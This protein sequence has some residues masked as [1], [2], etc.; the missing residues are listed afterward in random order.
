MRLLFDQNLS[1]RLVAALDDLFPGSQHVRLL[2]MAEADD[3]PIWE[4]AKANGF[5][6]VTHDSDYADWNKLRGAPP[7]IVWLRCGNTSTA[8]IEAKLRQAADR[9]HLL[10]D[11]DLGIE[12]LE[13]L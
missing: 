11:P 6:I 10:S 9:I 4:Y 2:G 3:L 5:V 12:V 8:Q 1:H 7:K 13:I